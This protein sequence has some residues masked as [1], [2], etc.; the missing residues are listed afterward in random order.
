MSDETKT[1]VIETS[2]I[3]VGGD[4]A[5]GPGT[6][7]A[8]AAP[9]AVAP[10]PGG[11]LAQPLP[12]TREKIELIKRTIAEDFSDD[13]LELF[14]Y[15]ANRTGLDPLAGQ[16]YAFKKGGKVSIGARI[17]GLRLR[18]ARTGRYMPG[19]ETKY[20]VDKSGKLIS[21]TVY[22]KVLLAGEWHEVSETSYLKEFTTGKG[23][24]V[25]KPRVMTA[26]T[27]EARALRRAFPAELS[28]VYESSELDAVTADTP[29]PAGGAGRRGEMRRPPREPKTGTARGMVGQ[30]SDRN[31]RTWAHVAGVWYFTTIV[32]DGDTLKAAKRT[33]NAVVIEWTQDG[34]D[35]QREITRVRVAPT[36]APEPREGDGADQPP[37]V[38]PEA[39][40][41]APE[42]PVTASGPRPGMP[43]AAGAKDSPWQ[44]VKAVI[45]ETKTPKAEWEEIAYF[46]Q[47]MSQ[48][49]D[50]WTHEQ[51]A[52]VI[53][54][55]RERAAGEGGA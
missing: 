14:L 45:D 20:D 38:E 3:P 13:E 7:L 36:A 29:P 5:D 21:A 22:V 28:G 47:G 24:W 26:K 10:A 15:Q 11:A 32:E 49:H 17:D 42:R 19:R 35:K 33:G 4:A 55:I 18:A 51:A 43:G 6:A 30:G 54:L 48:D 39:A 2:A 53:A 40:A 23:N 34:P 31:G 46:W 12:L 37:T 27:A 52:D 1:E 41:E 25:S 50:E 16:I 9:A 8:V 44:R